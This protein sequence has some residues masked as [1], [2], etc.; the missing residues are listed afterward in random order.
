MVKM[1]KTTRRKWLQTTG[2]GSL[3]GSLLAV[4]YMYRLTEAVWVGAGA[5]HAAEA[6]R[7]VLLALVVLALVTV[8]VGLG[9][10][11]LMRTVLLPATRGAF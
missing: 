7:A 6:P 8:A 2:I 10:S 9:S 11:M 4:G 3:A 1:W 5:G